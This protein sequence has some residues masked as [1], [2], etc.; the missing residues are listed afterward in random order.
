MNSQTRIE[1]LQKELPIGIDSYIT[2]NE[3]PDKFQCL[4]VYYHFPCCDCI[5]CKDETDYCKDCKHWVE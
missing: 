5:H 3:C 2:K 1:Q 4:E